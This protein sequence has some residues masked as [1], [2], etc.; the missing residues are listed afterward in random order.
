MISQIVTLLTGDSTLMALLTGGAYDGNSVGFISRQNTTAAFDTNGEL[1][2]CGL[3]NTE[4]ITPWG[5]MR[6]S[7]RQYVRI[8][9]YQRFGYGTIDQARQ[10]IYTLLHRTRLNVN[11]CYWVELSDETPGLDDPDLSCNLIALRY[12]VTLQRA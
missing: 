10:R 4:S 3:V 8:W 11:G 5:E 1:K 12:V 2:P 9:L 7:S 6:Y